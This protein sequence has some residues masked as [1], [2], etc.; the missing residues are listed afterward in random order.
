MR[1]LVLSNTPFLPRS[2]GNR[3]R[4]ASM[5]DYLLAGGHEVAMLM[6]P[7]VDR[8]EWDVDGMRARLA[9]LEIVDVEPD[10]VGVL[11]RA[12][13]RLA[14]AARRLSGADVPPIGV[15]DWCPP[16]FRSRAHDRIRDWRP[17]VALVEYV[18]LSACL[19]ERDADHPCVRVIDTHDLMHERRA[20]YDALGMAPQW[21]HTTAAEE[22]RGLLRADL[23]LAVQDAE[24]AALRV[25]VPERPVLTVPHAAP[26]APAAPADARRGR[27]LFVAS[28]NDLNV[29][30]LDWLVKDVWPAL[31]A[32]VPDVELVVCGD[33]ATKLGALPDGVVARGFVPSLDAEYAA[34]RVVV[35]PILAATG[36]AVKAVDALC[37]GRPLV[38]T[39]AGAAGLDA[40]EEH[41][42]S[43]AETA[44]EFAVAV[45]TLLLDDAR[46]QRAVAGATAQAARRFTPD[47]A[48]APLLAELE[49]RLSERG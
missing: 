31:R 40:G 11:D 26:L 49:R 39:R 5:L 36:L 19:V 37:R 3:A 17:D 12:R 9:W 43:V 2:A 30:G 45:R 18:F 27:L 4:I 48:F 42:V 10:P 29:R 38:A 32:A 21:F 23:V 15:D 35:S 28:Y 34:A 20:V 47:A 6:L 44:A 8:A 46:W 1:V 7:A 16:A 14:R 25:L 13:G 41:G 22:R 24:A 33:I